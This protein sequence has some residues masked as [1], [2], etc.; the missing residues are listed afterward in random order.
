MGVPSSEFPEAE[1]VELRGGPHDG[2]RV[3]VRYKDRPPSTAIR[4]NC[5]AR[6]MYSPTE[7][8]TTDGTRVYRFVAVEWD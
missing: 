7:Q 2:L 8:R 6:A 3:S 1:T 4:G 5:E